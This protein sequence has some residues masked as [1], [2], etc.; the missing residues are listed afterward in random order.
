MQNGS[1]NLTDVVNEIKVEAREFVSTR[2]QMFRMEMKDKVSALKVGV[3]LLIGAGVCGLIAFI[4]LNYALIAFL[5]ALFAPSPYNWCFA[6]LIV[7]VFYLIVA[8]VLYWIGMREIK[9]ETLAPA[10][11]LRVL[12]QDQIWLQN[13]ARSQV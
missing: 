13:Q 6:A 4:V 8:G 7:G 9:A 1:K 2:L 10:R 11:T 3:P 5:A 12:K